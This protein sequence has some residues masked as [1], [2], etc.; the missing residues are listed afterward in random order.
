MK[1][2]VK[3]KQFLKVAFLGMVKDKGSH[4]SNF[5]FL[6]T[7]KRVKII[8]V[9]SFCPF[10]ALLEHLCSGWFFLTKLRLLTNNFWQK[11]FLPVISFFKS[12][13]GLKIANMA[14]LEQLTNDIFCA[15]NE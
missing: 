10:K 9:K 11:F 5:I 4:F 7:Q 13:E 14:K 6:P 8:R 15:I 2:L 3:S 12:Y 1:K